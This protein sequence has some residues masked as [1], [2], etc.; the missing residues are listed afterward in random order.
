MSEHHEQC[1]VADWLD[2]NHIRFYAIPN[3]GDRN[4]VVAAKLKA[5]GVKRGVPDLCICV[6]T[7]EYAGLY[8]EMKYGKNKP[9]AEQRDWIEHLNGAGYMAV[10]CY[11]ADE[12]IKVIKGYLG[13]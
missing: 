6:K 11:S 4:V 2:W 9:T 10:V 13:L 5:E 12:A 3:G 1:A 8:V 7:K